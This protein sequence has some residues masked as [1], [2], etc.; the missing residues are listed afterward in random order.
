LV[1][2]P[3]VA[4]SSARCGAVVGFEWLAACGGPRGVVWLAPLN[5]LNMLI[6]TD[7]R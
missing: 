2:L 5:W 6:T 1:D 7:N 4:A 3:G